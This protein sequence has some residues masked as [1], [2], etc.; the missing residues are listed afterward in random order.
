[1][2]QTVEIKYF[3]DMTPKTGSDDNDTESDEMSTQNVAIVTVV[4]CVIA[5]VAAAGIFWIGRKFRRP[6]K[7]KH[8]RCPSEEES[9]PKRAL[10]R[11]SE[12]EI[13]TSKT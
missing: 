1:M 10:I 2:E 12:E 11:V 3:S 4:V 6:G 7:V 8:M 13:K 5:A 9:S